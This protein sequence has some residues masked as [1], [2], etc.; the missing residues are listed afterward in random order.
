MHEIKS[1][2]SYDHLKMDILYSKIFGKTMLCVHIVSIL[3][4]TGHM[5]LNNFNRKF[6]IFRWTTLITSHSNKFFV[7]S[8]VAK[9]LHK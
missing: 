5:C 9:Y 4:M 8:F 6:A 1:K 7:F 2:Q 3:N